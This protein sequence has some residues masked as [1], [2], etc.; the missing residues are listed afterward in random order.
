MI[1]GN[2]TQDLVQNSTRNILGN[3]TGKQQAY[4][5]PEKFIFVF[6]LPLSKLS[7]YLN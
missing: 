6:N 2:S 1:F 4:K 5:N 7:S 3:V